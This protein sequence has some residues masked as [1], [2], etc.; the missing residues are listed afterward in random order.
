MGQARNGLLRLAETGAGAARH[1]GGP[2]AA[3][4]FQPGD[5]R[6]RCNFRIR[7]ATGMIVAA[8]PDNII[9]RLRVADQI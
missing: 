4:V 9:F 3:P 6:V 7:A 8:V 2:G 5:D 1:A